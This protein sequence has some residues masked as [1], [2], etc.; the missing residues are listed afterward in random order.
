MNSNVSEER[1][2][3]LTEKQRECLRLVYELNSS[4]DIARKLR[5]SSH[6][7]DQRLRA[8]IHKLDLNSRVDA[9]I[10]LARHE[11]SSK[12]EDVEPYQSLIYQPPYIAPNDPTHP[13][14]PLVDRGAQQEKYT[15]NNMMQEEQRTFAVAHSPLQAGYSMLLPIFGGEENDLTIWQRLG[16][17]MVIAIGSALAFGSVLAGLGALAQLS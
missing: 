12:R 6:T 5:I 17:I 16:W 10:A 15:G 14:T 7:V 2:A 13:I 1:F 3:K 8:A 4:K 11:G 9:A